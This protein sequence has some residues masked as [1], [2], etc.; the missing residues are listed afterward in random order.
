MHR[1]QRRRPEGQIPEKYTADERI[2]LNP[3]WND[4]GSKKHV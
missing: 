3:I 4:K 2:E 1:A